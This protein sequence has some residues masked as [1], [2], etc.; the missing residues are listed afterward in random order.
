MAYLDFILSTYG[1]MFFVF[2]QVVSIN[3]EGAERV[4]DE[5]PSKYVVSSLL[6]AWESGFSVLGT[7]L[8]FPIW[9]PTTCVTNHYVINTNGSENILYFNRPNPLTY[10]D[11][12]WLSK[13]GYRKHLQQWVA[14]PSGILWNAFCV[15]NLVCTRSPPS[16]EHSPTFLGRCLK[17]TLQSTPNASHSFPSVP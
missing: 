10:P 9:D 14:S 6:S 7:L 15:A 4:D 2:F 17:N 1:P 11:A 5:Q 13:I 12:L 3:W 8:W 16:L